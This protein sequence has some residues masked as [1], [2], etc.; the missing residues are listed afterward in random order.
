M[1]NAKKMM[2]KWG[3]NKGQGLGKNKTGMTSCLV[4]RK[5]DG[6]STQGRI[7]MTKPVKPDK[8][9][10]PD[11]GININAGPIDW[12]QPAAL[13]S[14]AVDWGAIP[15]LPD[16]GSGDLS[17][18]TT[19]GD[20]AALKEAA[21]MASQ[22]I[23]ASIAGAHADATAAVVA[24][25]EVKR[26][27]IEVAFAD[28][29]TGSLAEGQRETANPELFD[30]DPRDV[31]AT[32]AAAQAQVQADLA[33]QMSGI[34]FPNLMALGAQ[35]QEQAQQL[36][37]KVDQAESAEKPNLFV[38][39]RQ[40]VRVRQFVRDD[41]RW[42][43][44]TEALR[45]FE[46]VTLAPSLLDLAKKILGNESRYPARIADDTDCVTEVTAWGTLLVRPRGTG[47]NITLAKRMLYE[48]LHPSGER[49]REDALITPDEMAEAAIRDQTTIFRDV[50]DNEIGDKLTQGVKRSFH[51]DLRRVGLGAEEEAINEAH[52]GEASK[53]ETKAITLATADDARLVARHLDDI[54]VATGAIALLSGVVLKLLGKDRYVR[55][56]EHL[57]KTLTETG[58][59]VALTDGFVLAQD[60]EKRR[61]NEGPA[62]QILIKIP[63]GP[64]TQ[65]V[66]KHLKMIERA[67]LADTLKLTSKA[68]QGKKTL[69]V[70][71]SKAAHERVKLMVKEI[72]EK[73]E[74]PMLN[75]VI[76]AASAGLTL[77]AGSALPVEI[78]IEPEC[79]STQVAPGVIYA[80]PILIRDGEEVKAEDLAQPMEENAVSMA[81]PVVSTPLGKGPAM[82]FL[83]A[84]R[85]ASQMAAGDSLF[86]G[87]PVPEFPAPVASAVKGGGTTGDTVA[88]FP[89]QP[90]GLDTIPAPAAE[91]WAGITE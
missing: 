67:A 21:N 38:K 30:I 12:G 37:A 79:Y 9:V 66:E 58:E 64:V 50:D 47:A 13:N 1:E 90:P 2:E 15:L 74:S 10:I 62:E 20:L 86:S 68:V 78:K 4:L 63:D 7:I 75:K 69:M 77:E 87:L 35:A 76:N 40:R 55:K 16:S 22:N 31:A 70:D 53:T 26:A 33:A 85:L 60:T 72:S 32:A 36:Q 80:A 45:Y 82:R 73:G 48:V 46:E 18:S 19:Q 6:S 71:G 44:G 59:W 3:W 8:E 28:E 23:L 17:S 65:K 49:L 25:S 88:Q 89:P 83:P 14:N 91:V 61:A 52:T 24:E 84:P 39:P 81:L 57:V 11:P 41:W 42:S 29:G 27:K 34:Q 43:K 5:Q 51:G 54:R 56:A